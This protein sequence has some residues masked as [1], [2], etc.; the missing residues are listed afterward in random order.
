M[1]TTIEM[2]LASIRRAYVASGFKN[3]LMNEHN[4]PLVRFQGVLRG[5]KKVQG[6][7]AIVRQPI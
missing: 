4:Q 2:Y 5:V 6:I 3:P 1:Y 7:N